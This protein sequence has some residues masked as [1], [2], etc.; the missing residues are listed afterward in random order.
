LSSGQENHHEEVIMS[1][2]AATPALPRR[3]LDI[4]LT[5]KQ[6]ARLFVKDLAPL[7]IA[8]LIAGALS[9]LSLGILAGPLFAGLYGMVISRVRDGRQP[10][11]SDVFSGLDRFW[12]YAGA[13]LTLVA[14]VG[15]ASITIVGGFVL[16]TIWLYVFPLMVDRGLGLGEAMKASKNMVLRAGFWEHL[17]LVVVLFVIVSV[18]NGALAILAAPFVVVAVTAAYFLADAREEALERA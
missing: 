4:G 17:A 11:V 1:T 16:A 9:V 18:A 5:L 14:L 6:A 13:A 12:S 8:A 3:G 7:L 15:L 2:I 10:E